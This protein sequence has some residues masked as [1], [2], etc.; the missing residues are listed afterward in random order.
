MHIYI[1]A[2]MCERVHM[3]AG[4]GERER[5]RRQKK[6]IKEEAN[7]KKFGMSISKEMK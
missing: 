3:H 2:G 7:N 6:R 5:E 1:S 4:G